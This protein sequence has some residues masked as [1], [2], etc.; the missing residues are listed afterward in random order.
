MTDAMPEREADPAKE[1]ATRIS[2]IVGEIRPVLGSV[3]PKQ[4]TELGDIDCWPLAQAVAVTRDM[5]EKIKRP[6]PSRQSPLDRAAKAIIREVKSSLDA[7]W[8]KFPGDV[9]REI[10][11]QTYPRIR[12]LEAV[13]QAVADLLSDGEEINVRHNLVRIMGDAV[14]QTW[15]RAICEVP[16]G[17]HRKGALTRA[18]TTLLAMSGVTLGKDVVSDALRGPDRV[19]RQR[20]GAGR[21]RAQKTP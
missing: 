16:L 3:W 12:K 15:Q 11:Y 17:T 6:P 19:N 10:I 1:W 9:Q 13:Q 5:A 4:T 18:V 20:S 2:G 14:V 8:S 21:K 7:A